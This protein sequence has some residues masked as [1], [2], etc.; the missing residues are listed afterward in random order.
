M[1]MDG[2]C[3]CLPWMKALVMSPSVWYT[4]T[5][6][7]GRPL[8][9]TPPAGRKQVLYSSHESPRISYGLASVCDLQQF[10]QVLVPIVDRGKKPILTESLMH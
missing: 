9:L 6:G 1:I 8:L 7:I 2:I 3:R 4:A 5:A 10:H